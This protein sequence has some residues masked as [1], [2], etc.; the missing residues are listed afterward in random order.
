MRLLS[1]GLGNV[2]YIFIAITS[3]STLTQSD[4]ICLG[5]I[6]ESNRNI[7]SF[8]YLKPFNTVQTTVC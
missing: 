2:V 4:S 7:Q 1:G 6:Y 5:P 8:L 3:R